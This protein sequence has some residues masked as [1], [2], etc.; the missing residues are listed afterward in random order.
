[1]NRKQHWEQ[2]YNSK[3]PS[4]VGWTQEIPLPSLKMIRGLN[5]PKTASIIDIGGGDSK[6][7]EF[8][9]KDGFSDLTVLDI[10]ESGIERAKKRL[11]SLAD[12][13][14]WII[15]DILDF[16]PARQY[17][18]WHDRAA[19]HFLTGLIEAG[20]Y[21]VIA[22]KAVSGFMTIGAFSNDG[23]KKCSGLEIRQYDEVLLNETFSKGFELINSFREDHT[24]PSGNKQNFIFG[25]FRKHYTD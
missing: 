19:F 1:M 25:L 8:L 17:D 15:S 20:K 7:I 9:L 18:L 3:G 5:L 14:N 4:D 13:I 11:G 21:T 22:D 12:G 16:V 6:L 2:V 23:P 24:T 10:S